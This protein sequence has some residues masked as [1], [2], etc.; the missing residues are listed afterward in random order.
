MKVE[1]VAVSGVE[2]VGVGLEGVA[3]CVFV[4]GVGGLVWSPFFFGVS[5]G[6]GGGGG[7]WNL[8]VW[9]IHLHVEN[10]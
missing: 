9:R 1:G 3:V 2:P 5:V 10:S 4:V 7:G 6:G 8:M